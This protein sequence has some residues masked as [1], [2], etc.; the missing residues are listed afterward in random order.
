MTTTTDT[1]A[2]VPK[3]SDQE[4][5]L[6]QAGIGISN[7]QLAAIR[8]QAG[9]QTI[10]N[11]ATTPLIPGQTSQLIEMQRQAEAAQ[12]R[13]AG[14]QPTQDAA[15]QRTAAMAAGGNAVTP[16][17]AALIDQATNSALALGRS[18][19]TAQSQ[20]QLN[21]LRDTLAPSRGLRTTDTPILDR[22]DIIGQAGVRS[23]SDLAQSLSG[24]NAQARLAYPLQANQLSTSQNQNVLNFTQSNDQF[25]QQLAES[26]FQNRLRLTGQTSS[27][28]LGLATG[29][30]GTLPSLVSSLSS[31]RNAGASSSTTT[32]GL[33]TA[34]GAG[35]SILGGIG[36]ILSGVGG[37]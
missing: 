24:Q 3:P 20:D 32:G 15:L 11:Q 17:Q 6:L 5:Q 34:I 30:S 4:K 1:N 18:Q 7:E 33:G 37:F 27:Q 16:Q 9:Q 21:Q 22:G 10:A 12:G 14:A 36:G 2:D 8:A 25:A 35:G 28:G 23:M 19:I 29:N 13:S 26:A 31:N